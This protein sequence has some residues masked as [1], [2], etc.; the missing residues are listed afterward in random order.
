MSGLRAVPRDGEGNRRAL[1]GGSGT[2]IDATG[3]F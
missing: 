3:R 1:R 2:F